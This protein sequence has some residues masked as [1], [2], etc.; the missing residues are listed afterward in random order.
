MGAF[1]AGVVAVLCGWQAMD[2]LAQQ[3][4]ALARQLSLTPFNNYTLSSRRCL[5]G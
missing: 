3:R 5:H 1:D 4:L 2:R